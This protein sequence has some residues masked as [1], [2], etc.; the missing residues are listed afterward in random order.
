[1]IA[2]QHWD[3]A[4]TVADQVVGAILAARLSAPV[5]V[6][7]NVPNLP[8]QEIAGWRRAEVGLLPPRAV[9]AARLEAVAG[10]AGV[11]AVHF[12]WGDAVE[13][14]PESDGGAIERNEITVSF[15]SRLVHEPR[16]DLD[17]VGAAL[18][19]LLSGQAPTLLA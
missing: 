10:R 11:Y 16:T 3:V 12:E 18:S 8:L 19:G 17:N 7:L 4:A 5:V 1:M 15:L 9:A 2:D 13:L 14:P 6:N